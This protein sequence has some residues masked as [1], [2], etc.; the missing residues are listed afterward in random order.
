M[1]TRLAHFLWLA[2]IVTCSRGPLDVPDT[3]QLPVIQLEGAESDW[4]FVRQ[5]ATWARGNS[6]LADN[7]ITGLKNSGLLS[8][9]ATFTRSGIGM[10]S[11]SATIRLTPS[12]NTV[13]TGDGAGNT[14]AASL[15]GSKTFSHKFDAWRSSDNA[16]VLEL[17][18]DDPDSVDN[19]GALL[20]YNLHLLN[21]A[22]FTGNSAVVESY[23]FG[24][25]GAL[26][27]TYSWSNGPLISGGG[28]DKGRVV[29][30]EVFSGTQL[31]FRSVIKTNFTINCGGTN[32]VYY[33]L[34]Y[35]TKTTGANETTARFGIG[36]GPS[37]AQ[38]GT[39]GTAD[40]ICGSANARNYGLFSVGGFI[41]DGYAAANIPAS[42]PAANTSSPSYGGSPPHVDNAFS[43]TGIVA[44]G[45]GDYEDTS[46]TRM[47]AL[48]VQFKSSAAP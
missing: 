2:L 48:N 32:L 25:P 8:Q 46:A 14:G 30:N 47:D 17:F 20:Y 5:S 33:T 11:I 45:A 42:Y 12:A 40:G 31:C 4:G 13:I 1:K 18:F 19:D 10:G 35:M 9:S 37:G 29:L 34:A 3:I 43:R 26:K 7:L 16:K 28:S 44:G 22:V 39:G 41:G 38:A 36:T 6:S 27:Q 24:S 15:V 23:S 21:P